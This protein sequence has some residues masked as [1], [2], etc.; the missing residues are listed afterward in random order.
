MGVKRFRSRLIIV[1][2][3]N[4]EPAAYADWRLTM[5]SSARVLLYT[6]EGWWMPV[7]LLVCAMPQYNRDFRKYLMAAAERSGGK[8]L[9][10]LCRDKLILSWAGAE[11]AEYS[12]TFNSYGLRQ[13]ISDHLKPGP[14]L[15]LTGLGATRLDERGV[16]VRVEFAQGVTWHPLGIR[17]SRRPPLQ[18]E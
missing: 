9:H 18:Y 16:D 17:C 3:D 8:S 12:T 14:I 6:D 10:I 13:I 4:L 1:R 2:T 7:N 5:R 15:G 11:R